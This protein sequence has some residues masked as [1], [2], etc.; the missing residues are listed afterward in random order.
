MGKLVSHLH[1]KKNKPKPCLEIIEY[2]QTFNGPRPYA[3]LFSLQSHITRAD[4]ERF[5]WNSAG[6]TISKTRDGKKNVC[7]GRMGFK[8]TCQKLVSTS[9]GI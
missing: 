2:T 7:F 1:Y 8:D 6:N 3:H 4:R 9:I 5:K